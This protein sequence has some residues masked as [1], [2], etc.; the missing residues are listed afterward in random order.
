MDVVSR[1]RHRD[2]YARPA[3]PAEVD[4]V[5]WDFAAMGSPP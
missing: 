3:D 1:G 2:G 5:Q 4:E